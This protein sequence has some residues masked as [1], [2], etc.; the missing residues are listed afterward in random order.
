MSTP[1]PLPEKPASLPSPPPI[2]PE[3]GRPGAAQP[4]TAAPGDGSVQRVFDTVAGPNLRLRDNLIQ[5]ACVVVGTAAGA[6][7]GMMLTKAGDPPAAFMLL[8]ALGGM[9]ASLLLS[10][11][12]IGIVRLVNR[13][14]RK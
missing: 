6:G 10:G 12:I 2:I 5:L 14:K 4:P 11:M 9:V 7:I 1:P 3:Y 8:G 13:P